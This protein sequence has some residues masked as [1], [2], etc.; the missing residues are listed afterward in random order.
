MR[1]HYPWVYFSVK[2]G[3]NVPPTALVEAAPHAQQVIKA[4]SLTRTHH[5]ESIMLFPSLP[6]CSVF[7]Q[8]ISHS[9]A[10]PY[11]QIFRKA[12]PAHNENHLYT[13]QE[14]NKTAFICLDHSFTLPPQ[15]TSRYRI[16]HPTPHASFALSKYSCNN[17]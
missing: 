7:I 5:F 2:R 9:T 17:C 4:V 14:W 1:F 16:I 6:L 8:C 3:M 11:A 12:A 15:L 13:L 10:S